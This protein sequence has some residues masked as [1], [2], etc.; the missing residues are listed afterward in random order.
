M[1]KNV[2]ELAWNLVRKSGMSMVDALKRAWA[3]VKL[4]LSLSNT[5][6]RGMWV[7]FKKVNGEVTERL[8]TRTLAYVP[9]EH[10][11]KNSKVEGLTLPM[12]DLIKGAWISARVENLIL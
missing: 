12:F 3:V 7:K 6:E 5:D 8:V 9:A 2:F 4:K 10:L 11:P 1:K